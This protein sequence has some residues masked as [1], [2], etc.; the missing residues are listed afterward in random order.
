[1]LE[2]AHHRT[3][4]HNRRG[5]TAAVAVVMAVAAASLV[6]AAAP[7]GS[8]APSA[9]S[10]QTAVIDVPGAAGKSRAAQKEALRK[11][12]TPERVQEAVRAGEGRSAPASAP[13]PAPLAPVPG[14]TLDQ[15][16]KILF[17]F[18]G[19]Q[20]SS[21]TGTVVDTPSGKIVIT[22]GHCLEHGGPGGEWFTNF[23]FLPA[24]E[25]GTNP[26]GVFT[27]ENMAA[28]SLWSSK[29]DEAHDYGVLV[30]DE[31]N[32]ETVADAA[33]AL[34]LRKT[35]SATANVH[36]VGYSADAG[37][38][39]RNQ[40]HCEDLTEPT[41]PPRN[42]IVAECSNMTRGSSGGP[43]LYN[44]DADEETGE[45]YGVNSLADENGMIATARFDNRTLQLVNWMD[46]AARTG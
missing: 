40:Q 44:F 9:V 36:I 27:V 20:P 23:V 17:N 22:A 24:H 28:D 12:W 1:M 13:A 4:G 46:M 43:W 38:D 32:G 8:A 35:P 45:I 10:R 21:C 30:V 3:A 42:L 41:E 34:P 11:Y 37:Y 33:G 19:G 15:V 39:G 5:R 2:R 29:A 6:G 16:G 26:L 7:T 31:L 25:Q 14:R 18:P